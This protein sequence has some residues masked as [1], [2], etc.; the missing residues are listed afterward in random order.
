MGMHML[1]LAMSDGHTP[2]T[3]FLVDLLTGFG[4]KAPDNEPLANKAILVHFQRIVT[5]ENNPTAFTLAA[6]ISTHE[7]KPP[8]TTLEY[9]DKAIAAGRD[10]PEGPPARQAQHPGAK[11]PAPTEARGPKWYKESMCHHLRGKTLLQLGLRDEAVASFEVAALE[12]GMVTSCLELAKLLPPGD[13]GRE[14]HLL[15][16]A[17]GGILEA[18]RLLE[19]DWA[20]KAEAEGLG[21][22]ERAIARAMSQEWARVVGEAAGPPPRGPRGGG[23]RGLV[24]RLRDRLLPR[25]LW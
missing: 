1:A 8:T 18:C 12:L 15:R 4:T 17:Q 6:I 3:L 22:R 11:G 23:L 2:S 25:A 24:E 21:E 10:L 13:S 14:T 20:R 9:L 19:R 16:A 5:I 7:G